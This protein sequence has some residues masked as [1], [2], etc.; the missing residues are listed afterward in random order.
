MM[1]ADERN[2]RVYSTTGTVRHYARAVGLQPAEQTI[3]QAIET[4]L[5][6]TKMLDLGVGGGRTTES[7]AGR[8]ARYVA[9][10]YSTPMIHAARK[11]FHGQPYEF[12]VGD[13]RSIPFPD[14]AFDFVLFSHNGIDY[15]DPDD[16]LRVLA[17]VIRVVS[18]G[19][20]F[21]FSTHNL[22]R[23]D[24][25]FEARSGEGAWC[26]VR[27]ALRRARLRHE[28]PSYRTLPELPLAMVNDG[29]FGF[30]GCTYHIR[31]DA[32]LDQLHTAGFEDI[33]VYSSD[34]GLAIPAA[35][36]HE[37]RDPWLYFLCRVA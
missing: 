27:N 20:F 18:P 25:D 17:E 5:P 4:D 9:L 21:A 10:D 19:G 28:N 7:F 36:I 22:G 30:R 37:A 26:R 34:Q 6:S 31:A 3:L 24:L 14:D 11:R 23:H 33:T 29:A 32:Q 35:R 2:R 8:V 12:V 13:A 1:S 15:V 16:R